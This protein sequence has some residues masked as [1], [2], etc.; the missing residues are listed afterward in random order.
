MRLPIAST[1]VLASA[2]LLAACSKDPKKQLEGRWVGERVEHFSSAQKSRAEGWASG[3]SFEFKGSKVTVTVP[4]ESPRE[5]TYQI[6]RADE[7]SLELAFLRPGGERD[8]AEF[9][10]EGSDHLR[11]QLGDGRSILFRKA[12]D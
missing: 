4:A 9:Q 1:V 6:T 2:T 7:R 12:T 8:R 3:A 11:W 5:G 10:L